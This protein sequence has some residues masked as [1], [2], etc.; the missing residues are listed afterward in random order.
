[1]I[2]FLDTSYLFPYIG[3]DLYNNRKKKWILADLKRLMKMDCELLYS[4]LSLFELYAKTLKLEIKGELNI[5]L[6]DIHSNLMTLSKSD[7]FRKVDY[8][9][10]LLEHNIIRELKNIH[11]DTLDVIILY[12]SVGF[13]DYLITMDETLKRTIN[14]SSICMEWIKKQNPNFKICSNNQI[15]KILKL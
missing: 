14:S 10:Q 13:A 8:L 6:E 9:P 5:S 11:P 2:F 7:R 4:D 12:L 15:F 3:V 1:M